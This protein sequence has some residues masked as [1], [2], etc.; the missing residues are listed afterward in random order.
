MYR[1]DDPSSVNQLPVPEAALTEGFFTEGNPGAGI[2][3][4]LLRASWFNMIQEE[5]R[6]IVV[7]G[8][9]TPSK[10]AYNQ[11]MNALTKFIQAGSMS[12]SVDTGAQNAYAVTYAPAIAAVTPGLLIFFRAANANTGPSTI[13]INGLQPIALVGAAHLPLAGNEIVANSECMAIYNESISS[14]V[15][16]EASGGAV[17]VGTASQDS[18][19]VQLKQMTS[20]LT[21]LSNTLTASIKSWVNGLFAGSFGTNNYM[22]IDGLIIQ[23]C[24]AAGPAASGAT[25]NVTFPITFPNACFN[26]QLTIIGALGLTGD[27]GPV[28]ISAFTNSGCTVYS[29]NDP[30]AI[31][32]VYVLAFGY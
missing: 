12:Y 1:I 17:Q 2:S 14:F 11:I 15:L 21:N 5:L 20:S 25:S 4:T 28:T 9:L 13:A 30:S 3:A 8:G 7:A 32:S 23:W 24:Q 16:L 26:I 18:H 27:N 31:S 19:A 22:S 29:T 6:N 10:T